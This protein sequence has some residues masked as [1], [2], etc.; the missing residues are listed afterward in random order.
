MYKR[1]E[2]QREKKKGAVHIQILYGR[3]MHFRPTKVHFGAKDMHCR[4]KDMHC[5]KCIRR[6]GSAYLFESA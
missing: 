1:K 4:K 3:F 6:I 5:Q 2:N